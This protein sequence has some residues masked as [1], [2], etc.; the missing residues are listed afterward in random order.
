MREEIKNWFEQSK[1]DLGNAE[2]LFEGERYELAAFSCQQSVEKALKALIM[3]EKKESPGPVHS[4]IKLGST[5]HVP[6]RFYPFLRSLSA[7]YVFSRYPDIA[8]G[9]PYKQYTQE[10]IE[11]YIK[12]A[13]ELMKWI[14]TQIKE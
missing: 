5:V 3:L 2:Y 9:V 11:N 10:I 7:E 6:S 1:R 13:K 12:N 4:L 8:E 14:H